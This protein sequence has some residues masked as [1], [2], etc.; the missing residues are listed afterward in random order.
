MYLFDDIFHFVYFFDNN[1][2]LIFQN[3]TVV[4]LRS[5]LNSVVQPVTTIFVGT[6]PELEMSLYTMCFYIRPNLPCPIKLGGTEFIIIAN[7]I[8][9]FGKDILISAYPEI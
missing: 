7:A 2:Y 4:K 5:S 9:Y 3:G 8:N 1:L 6:S